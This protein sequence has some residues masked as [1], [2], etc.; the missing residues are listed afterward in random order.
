MEWRRESL[1]VT[2][3][4]PIDVFTLTG[5]R[6]GPRLAV[7]GGVHGDEPEG[8][9][10]ARTIAG[11]ALDL[12]CG[13]L[14]VVPVA[15]PAAFAADMRAGPDGG[16]LARVFPGKADG[17]PTERV[18]AVLTGH[19]LSKADALVD[20]HTAGRHYDMPLLAGFGDVGGEA[21]AMARRMAEDFG[22]DIV[23]RHPDVAVGRTL[24]VMAARGKPAIYTEA[25]GGGTLE[26]AT[27]ERYVEGVRRVMASFGMLAPLPPLPVK[28]LAVAG[29][30]NLDRDV[31][32]SP[33]AGYFCASVNAGAVVAGGDE[34]GRVMRLDEPPLAVTAPYYGAVMYLRRT[35][36]VDAETPLA[37]LARLENNGNGA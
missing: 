13:E 36:L 26:K 15:H 24:S 10:A 20:L 32:R 8:V 9:F 34:L 14:V 3:A 27:F 35:A 33:A 5:P 28:P 22:A 4:A 12:L 31:M 1:A 16:N 19:V 30:G 29:P 17:A 25:R 11:M 7:F 21:A 2:G 18:A 6:P 23:W 37:A